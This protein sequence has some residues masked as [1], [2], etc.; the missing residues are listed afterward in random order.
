MTK[1]ASLFPIHFLALFPGLVAMKANT[2]VMV[3]AKTQAT[4]RVKMMP[5]T[6][7][8]R[9]QVTFP[10]H[11]MKRRGQRKQMRREESRV[12]VMLQL[13]ALT[14]GVSRC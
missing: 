4:A 11:P 6:I 12:Q 2:T 3:L 7:C 1:T 9:R 5:N 14:M 8:L 13:F 10:G